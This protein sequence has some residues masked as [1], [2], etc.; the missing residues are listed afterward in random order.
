MALIEAIRKW[1][2]YEKSPPD[3]SDLLEGCK[4]VEYERNGSVRWGEQI[5]VIYKHGNE[6]V[7]V[8]DVEPATE[9]QGWGDYGE[10]TIYPVI[11]VDKQVT[12]TEYQKVEI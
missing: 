12:V 8:E 2:E 6:Y 11:A 5:R 10:P 7:A 1:Y 3:G 9:M 4:M